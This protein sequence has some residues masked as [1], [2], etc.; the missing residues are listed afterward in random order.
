MKIFTVTVFAVLL[1]GCSTIMEWVPS[2]WDDN[3][4]QQ[5]INIR[6]T[7]HNVNCAENQT[8][9]A[10][11]LVREIQWFQMYSESKGTLQ[12]D[13]IRLVA[14]IQATAED[15]L[16]RAE[17]GASKGYCEIKR[18]VLIEQSDKAAAAVLGRY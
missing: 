17:S 12:K 3:Q 4:S 2:F 9:Q 14:P 10:Q 7:A 13:V 11:K 18:R 15:W 1:S 6:Q 8:Q 16:R 5:I